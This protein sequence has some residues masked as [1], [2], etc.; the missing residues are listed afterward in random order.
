M[1]ISLLKVVRD[2]VLVTQKNDHINLKKQREEKH[3]KEEL[4]RQHGMTK[5]SEAFIDTLYYHEMYHSLACWKSTAMVERELKKLTSK[6]AKV[7]ALKENIRMRV[8]GLGWTD[9]A[10]TWSNRGVQLSVSELTSYLKAIIVH[11]KKGEF[12]RSHQS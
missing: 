6:T 2:D 11:Q 3:R 8:L 12:L 9:L 7:Y 1:R 10:I 5:A 4:L